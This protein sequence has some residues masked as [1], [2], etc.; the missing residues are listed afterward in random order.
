MAAR[1]SGNYFHQHFY[2]LILWRFFFHDSIQAFQSIADILLRQSHG[3]DRALFEMSPRT[4]SLTLREVSISNI[5]LST[6]PTF[7]LA[8]FP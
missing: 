6:G 7:Y 4:L 2:R 8:I 1:N 3:V 5:R